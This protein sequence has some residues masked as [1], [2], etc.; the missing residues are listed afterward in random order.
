MP[1]ETGRLKAFLGR[2]WRFRYGL[3]V[4]WSFCVVL[5]ALF[6]LPP[7]LLRYGCPHFLAVLSDFFWFLLFGVSLAFPIRAICHFCGRE[8]GRGLIALGLFPLSLVIPFALMLILSFFA[9][10]GPGDHYSDKLTIPHDVPYETPIPWD[11]GRRE[12][13]M[14][15]MTLA[16]LSRHIA[17]Q[18][19]PKLTNDTFELRCRFQGGLFSAE[20]FVNPGEPGTLHLRA[21]EMT[22]GSP[23]SVKTLWAASERNARWSHNPSEKFLYEVPKITIYEGDWGQY[24]LAR[25]EVW[26][27]PESGGERKLIEKVFKIDG[28]TR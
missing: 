22:K 7:F 9:S 2:V 28:W 10:C 3:V 6:S 1:M 13:A 27:V 17:S 11:C 12:E 5:A 26:F 23:L 18:A 25:F 8:W 24:Y 4:P 20:A 19:A 14:R 16:E 15:R 21:F